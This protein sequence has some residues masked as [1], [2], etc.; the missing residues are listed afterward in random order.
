MLAQFVEHLLIE[1]A[2]VR[3]W[4]AIAAINIPPIPKYGCPNRV[5]KRLGCIGLRD[6]T[7]LQAAA[8]MHVM[9]KKAAAGIPGAHINNEHM[10]VDEDSGTTT[11]SQETTKATDYSAS[12][13]SALQLTAAMLSHA[14]RHPTS[15]ATLYTHLELS[16]YP[17]AMLAFF[18]PSSSTA[19]PSIP[20]CALYHGL[21]LPRFLMILDRKSVV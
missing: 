13:T 4:T 9:A 8:A 11:E 21:I 15:K 2:K 14:L 12:F 16:L 20:S 6:A 5:L 19:R 3:K 18:P 7:G 10:D 17:T 1:G